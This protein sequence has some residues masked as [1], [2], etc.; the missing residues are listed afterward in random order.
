MDQGFK[1]QLV[2]GKVTMTRANL[3]V[4]LI[5]VAF[6]AVTEGWHSSLRLG[7]QAPLLDVCLSDDFVKARHLPLEL[8]MAGVMIMVVLGGRLVSQ[9]VLD[10]SEHLTDCEKYATAVFLLVVN[11][12]PVAQ[13][14][15]CLR[16]QDLG[17]I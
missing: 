16:L 10:D 1:A 9:F 5:K 3:E 17:H 7:L 6:G 14:L 15:L 2:R 13:E 11:L 8:H 4:R 12:E